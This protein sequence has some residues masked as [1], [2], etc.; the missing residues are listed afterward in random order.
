[1]TPGAETLDLVLGGG[2]IVDGTGRPGRIGHVGIRGRDIVSLSHGES[3]HAQAAKQVIDVSGKVVAPGFID[4]HTHDDRAVIATPDMAPKVTQGCTTVVVGNC[5]ISLAPMTQEA[6]QPP[7]SILGQPDDFRFPEMAGYLDAVRVAKPAV[8][9]A[10]LTGHMSLRLMA[11]ADPFAPASAAELEQMGQGLSEALDAG[12]LG[13]S[14]GLFYGPNAGAS[15]EEVTH[16]VRIASQAGGIYATHIRDERAGV[17]DALTEAFDTSAAADAPV[18]ISHHKCAGVENHGRSVETLALISRRSRSQRIGLDAYPYAAGSTVLDPRFVGEGYPVML[19]WS[20]DYPH[21][22][23][24]EISDIA[25]EWGRTEKDAAARL[26]PGGAIYFSTDER[27]VERI[28]AYPKTMIGSDGLPHDE[29]PHPRLWGTFPRVLAHY[30]RARR[31]FDLE[32]AICKMTDIPARTFGLGARG[33]IAPGY[34]ADITV[35][36]PDTVEDRATFLEPQKPA[37]GIEHVLVAG[38]PALTDGKPTGQ[39][40]GELINRQQTKRRSRG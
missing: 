19:A 21:L 26:Q 34:A 8:N 16:L 6:F 38:V 17:I 20:R 22:A 24:R 37:R 1:M 32:T 4:V 30:C 12:A 18:V 27:D 7:F 15:M 33:R 35:F 40:G 14:T 9:V 10:V 23:G 13:F 29:H 28:L 39:G 11:M 25:S 2:L 5:G 31:V 3:R 36:D